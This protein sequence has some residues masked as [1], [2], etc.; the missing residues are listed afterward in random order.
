MGRMNAAWGERTASLLEITPDDRVLEIG[1]GPGVVIQHVSKL[2]R[3]VAGIDPSAEMVEQARARNAAAI[4]AGRVGLRLASVERIPFDS[5][6]FDK[7][8]AINSMQTWPDARCG[9]QEIFRVLKPGGHIALGFTPHSGQSKAGLTETLLA[10]GF[11]EVRLVEEERGFC[12]LATKSEPANIKPDP[13]ATAT[14][15]TL[16]RRE[17]N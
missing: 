8:L 13:G 17:A 3:R 6:I 9:L 12:V 4:R 11:S 5:N 16:A 1:F 14:A 7:A 15:A 2:A 10:A